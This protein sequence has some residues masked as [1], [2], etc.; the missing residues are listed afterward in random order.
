MR[1]LEKML[2]IKKIIQTEPQ[3]KVCDVTIVKD[4][5]IIE[6]VNTENR[7]EMAP[8]SSNVA[9]NNKSHSSPVQ[10]T[11]RPKISLENQNSSTITDAP[12]K[13]GNFDE[14]N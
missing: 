1:L 12:I 7:I 8:P 3:K 5:A 9:S 10:I 2:N 6:T 13:N 14:N 11:Q 4:S